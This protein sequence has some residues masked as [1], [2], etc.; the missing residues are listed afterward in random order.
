MSALI[1]FQQMFFIDL[2]IDLRGGQIG[3]AK[4]FLYFAQITAIAEQ[5]RCKAVAQ[6]VRGGG[7]RQAEGAAQA[8]HDQ[9][10]D[11]RRQALALFAKEQRVIA[12]NAIG[13]KAEIVING[14]NGHR[15]HGHNALL[16][17]FAD[18]AQNVFGAAWRVLAIEIERF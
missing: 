6:G 7:I 9:L 8:L 13:A 5:M 15:Q 12:L 3:V 11:A 16:A 14:V 18:D 1:C 17:A 4:Q 10:D 2:R